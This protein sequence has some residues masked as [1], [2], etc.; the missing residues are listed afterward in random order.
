[1]KKS[2]APFTAEPW[3]AIRERLARA[4]AD[5]PITGTKTI[6]FQPRDGVWDNAY[7]ALG[8]VSGHYDWDT[9][10]G[11]MI[12]ADVQAMVRPFFHAA[13]D[14]PISFTS[15]GTESN[16]LALKAARDWARKTKPHIA[17][18]EILMARCT[19]VCHTKAAQLLG[20][21]ERR[22]P[23]T[24]DHRAD[25]TA[26]DRAIGPNTIAVIASYPTDSHGVCDDV[27]AMAAMAEKHGL[28]CHVDA[29]FGGYIAPFLK[30]MGEKLP[31]FDFRVPGVRSIAA[32]LHKMGYSP[33][34]V[35]SLLLRDAAD[36]GHLRFRFEGWDGP[37]MDSDKIAGTRSFDVLAGAWATLRQLGWEGFRDRAEAMRDN[38]RALVARLKAVRGAEILAEPEIGIVHFRVAGIAPADLGKALRANGHRPYVTKQP[39]GIIVCAGP[40]LPAE[41]LDR[42]VRDIE[43]A[44]RR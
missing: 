30:E 14:A 43:D 13:P 24:P 19:H 31:D 25:V 33:I 27:P 8:M 3:P 5:D 18:P 11:R 4:L 39:A 44:V 41:L 16:L 42:Y 32:D 7:E 34:G 2:N 20:L 12:V 1:M 38:T 35:S 36:A 15:G 22:V 26:M 37:A 6:T 40:E 21:G 10:A 9:K 29:S 28:W 17:A 23:N